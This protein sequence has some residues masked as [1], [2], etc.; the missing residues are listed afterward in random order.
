MSYDV[1]TTNVPLSPALAKI[2]NASKAVIKATEKTIPGQK[3]A[4]A[5]EFINEEREVPIAN[6]DLSQYRTPTPKTVNEDAI[7]LILQGQGRKTVLAGGLSSTPNST[8]DPVK[9]ADRLMESVEPVAKPM[10]YD[11]AAAKRTILKEVVMN[12][13][14]GGILKEAITKIVLEEVLN[15]KM[16]VPLLEKHFDKLMRNFMAKRKQA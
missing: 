5:G 16:I 13:K 3:P 7:G 10:T 8:Y 1:Q 11:D 6:V 14:Q 2:L 9:A 12:M 4:P 15:E